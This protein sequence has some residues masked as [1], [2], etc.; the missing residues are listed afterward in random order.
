MTAA[1]EPL[2]LVEH[3]RGELLAGVAAVIGH[4]G[5]AR[6]V[7]VR[8]VVV[9]VNGHVLT[10]DGLISQRG[11]RHELVALERGHV[12]QKVTYAQMGQ[13]DDHHGQHILE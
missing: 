5:P 12:D 11:W 2:R 4:E 3:N 8:V 6:V 13:N 9:H 1:F 7:R 10:S